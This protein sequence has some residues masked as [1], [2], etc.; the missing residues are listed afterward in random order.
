MDTETSAGQLIDILTEVCNA[1]MTR[2]STLGGHR[3]HA[4]WW[5]ED[6]AELR[7]ECLRAKR[8]ATRRRDDD[9]AMERYRRV[10]KKLRRTIR[11]SKKKAWESLCE[12]VDRDPWGLPYRIIMKKIGNRRKIPGL[13]IPNWAHTIVNT[14]FPSVIGDTTEIQQVQD[15]RHYNPFTNDEVHEIGKS[16]KRHKAPGPDGIPN[17]IITVVCDQWPELFRDVFNLC[18]EK[19]RF[20]KMWKKQYL[21]LLRKGDKPLDDLSMM[22]MSIRYLWEVPGETNNKEARS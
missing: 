3:K 12:E 13:T 9:R 22:I 5:N 7:R 20:P 11:D 6:I 19:G 17:E 10:R 21:V 8:I 4:Y 16:L 18:L 2:T 15:G 1:G 14:L